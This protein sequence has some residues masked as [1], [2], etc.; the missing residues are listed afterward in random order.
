MYVKLL[1][2]P[3]WDFSPLKN[4]HRTP[5]RK[6]VS[7]GSAPDQGPGL[8]D[9]PLDKFPMNFPG[10]PRVSVDNLPIKLRMGQNLVKSYAKSSKSLYNMEFFK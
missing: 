9:T 5:R 10:I 1:T 4:C 7:D 8:P 6:M 3:Y 2:L